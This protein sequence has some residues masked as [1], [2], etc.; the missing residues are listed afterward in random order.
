MN[1]RIV[2]RHALRFTMM[3]FPSL[4]LATQIAAPPNSN[5]APADPSIVKPVVD[6][7]TLSTADV[8]STVGAPTVVTSASP[9][10]DG[11]AT[12]Y[13]KLQVVIDNYAHLTLNL[14]L[15][16]W[17]QRLLFGGGPGAQVSP[18][19]M[20]LD[21]FVTASW[22]DL[23]HRSDTDIFAHDYQAR[24]NAGYRG[25]HLQVLA[26]KALIKVFYG[27][28]QKYA[29]YNACS[30]PGREGMMLVQRY[31]EDFD[32]VGAGCPPINFTIN[33]GIFQGWNVMTNTGA[34]GKPVLTEATL[35]ILHRAVLE[36]CDAADGVTDGIVSNPFAC[37]PDLK[38]VECKASQNPSTCLTP[39]QIHVAEELYRGARD[40]QGGKLT[41]S[42]VLPGSELAWT[43]TIVP[44]SRNPT[45]AKDGTSTSIR[46]MY[47]DPALAA[48]WDLSQ[49]KFD[50]ATFDATTK[51]RYLY[52]ATN[53][54]LRGFARAGHKLILWQAMGDTNVLPAQ[55]VLWYT[56]MR[57]E[58][59]AKQADKFVRFYELPGV[60]HCGGGDG[61]VITDLLPALMAWVERGV[62]PGALAGAHTPRPVRA[63]QQG[64][65]PPSATPMAPDLTR[66][67]YPYPFTARYTGK[68]DIGDAA[69]YVMGPAQPA[70]A[71]LSNWYG[72]DFYKAGFQKWCTGSSTGLQCKN[73]P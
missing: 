42:G 26:A 56:A 39:A 23:G 22:Q 65:G 34:D 14:P 24:V 72:S 17:T 1:T 30:E 41:P 40:D 51:L 16:N 48:D 3:A 13:C 68:G 27:Q 6:C 50:R 5:R 52:D 57:R 32:G 55:A 46:S 58:M 8:S 54:D 71:T 69:N 64:A 43:A 12:A 9:V 66:P 4:L 38:R 73:D 53:P 31:P 25:A 61:P 45:E 20:K 44:G 15:A 35:P 19:A 37:H 67:I 29:Y 11:S 18:G 62:A 36:Q 2:F 60:Y 49:I 63:P 10:D 21:Q 70:P 33:N 28:A 47:S 7:Q 59:G